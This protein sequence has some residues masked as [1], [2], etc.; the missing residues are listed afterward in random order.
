M[1]SFKLNIARIRGCPKPEEVE[2]ALSEFGL[3]ETEEFGV[4]SHSATGEAV[5][6]TIIRKTQQAV[7]KLDEETNEVTSTAVEKITVYPFAVRP[8]TEVLEIYSGPAGGIEQLGVFFSSCLAF[9][10]LTEPV[11]LDIL[12]AI[13][14]LAAETQRFQLRSARVSDYAHTSYM[15]GPYTPKFL[16]SEHGKDF[17]NEHAEHLQSASVKFQGPSGRVNLTL[18]P[19]TCFSFSCH[20]DDQ[21]A[22]QSILRKLAT[23]R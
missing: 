2:A 7:Q 21:P 12:S 10:T 19:K 3:P 5:F 18:S 11:E 15:A 16:D 1:A 13:E 17:L 23:G 20:E 4:L 9:P 14:K 22:V 6:A 8:Q